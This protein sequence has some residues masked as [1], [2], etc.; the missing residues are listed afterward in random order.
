M[1]DFLLD[2]LEEWYGHFVEEFDL[3]QFARL[4]A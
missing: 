1:K 3:E 4:R 2:K